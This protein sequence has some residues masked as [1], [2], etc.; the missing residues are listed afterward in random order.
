ME[1][2]SEEMKKN[3]LS[4]NIFTVDDFWTKDQC[5]TFIERSEEIGYLPAT[6]QTENGP[7]LLDFV[8]NNNRVMFK[9][10]GLAETL[11]QEIKPFAPEAIGNSIAKGVNELFRFYRYQPGQMFKKHRDNSFI[12]N[13]REASYY[14]FMIYL[15]LII[16]KLF[17]C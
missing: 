12:R 10:V 5:S 4:K 8:R 11:W 6:V 16:F 17:R 3:V 7:R 13:E 15:N 14:T 1:F 9:N 2:K